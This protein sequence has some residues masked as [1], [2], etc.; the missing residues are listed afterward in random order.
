[1]S[2]SL[3]SGRA[4]KALVAFSSI[5]RTLMA[6]VLGTGV[7]TVKSMGMVQGPDNPASTAY[8]MMHNGVGTVGGT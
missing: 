6:H 1:L 7:A 5:A 2:L 3:A 8:T 4:G